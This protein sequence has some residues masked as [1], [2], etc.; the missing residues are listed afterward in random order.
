MKIHW[1]Y[2]LLALVLLL[3]PIPFSMAFQKAL[4]KLRRR[5]FDSPLAAAGHWQNWVDLFRAGLGVYLLSQWAIELDP[6]V[7]GADFKGLAFIATLLSLAVLVQ[8]VRVLRSVQL[9]APVFF[10]CGITLIWGDYLQGAFAVIVGWVFAVGGKNLAFQLPTMAA[11]LAAASFVLGL[12]LTVFPICGLIVLPL[13]LS[14]LLRKRLLFAALKPET[15][16]ARAGQVT[17]P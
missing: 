15:F 17:T 7:P 13:V 4:H 11:A 6:E 3:P 1:L 16:P 14:V 12:R 8:T 5:D 2:L 10:L 9:V